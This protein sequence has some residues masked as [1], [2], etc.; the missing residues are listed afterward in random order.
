[1]NCIIVDDEKLAR[2]VVENYVLKTPDLNLI[3]KCSNA[4]E[5]F[6]HLQANTTIDL[7][8]LD[9]K[10]PEISGLELVTALKQVPDI[11][12]TTAYHEY[13]LDAFNLNAIDYLLKPFSYERFLQ[14]IAKSSYKKEINSINSTAQVGQNFFVKSDKKLVNINVNELLYI[15]GLKNY[16]VMI[17]QDGA[18]TIV[19]NTLTNLE[20]SLSPYQNMVR[21]HR[22]F[23]INIQAIKTITAHDV[24]L[25][26]N[27]EIPISPMY[28]ESLL[29]RLNML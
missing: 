9:I 27:K 5:L 7:V 16:Y 6:Q 12:F 18:T 2:D 26:N 19:H 15:E 13:A 25:N 11:I 3:G 23:F 28:R 1:M 29:A 14:A 24:V 4:I 21:I 17:T 10:M 22:S 8:F 20:Q